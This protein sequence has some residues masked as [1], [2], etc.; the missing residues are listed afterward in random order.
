M[1]LILLGGS[2]SVMTYGLNSGL[3]ERN[4]VELLNYSLGATSSLQNLSAIVEHIEDVKKADLIV[5]ESNVNDLSKVN[6]LG[7]DVGVVADSIDLYYR[8]LYLLEC[9]VIVIIMPFHKKN[10]SRKLDYTTVEI[11]KVHIQSAKKYGFDYID[12]AAMF[13]DLGAVELEHLMCDR[14]HPKPLLMHAIGQSIVQYSL[15]SADTSHHCRKGLWD[16]HV[17]QDLKVVTADQL[18]KVE[19]VERSNNRF[20]SR[21]TKISDKVHIPSD[22]LGYRLLGIST[23]G[24]GGLR[25]RNQ[26]AEI[27]KYFSDLRSFQ[28]LVA[29]FFIT[30]DTFLEHSIQPP[31]EKS[32]NVEAEFRSSPQL[33]SLLLIN[34]DA[35]FLS[36]S[37][38]DDTSRIENLDKRHIVPELSLFIYDSAR[39]SKKYAGAYAQ[40]G[41]LLLKSGE[42]ERAESN[43]KIALSINPREAKFYLTMSRILAKKGDWSGAV[44]SAE[45]AASLAPQNERIKAHLENLLARES[46]K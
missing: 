22:C 42:I 44:Q 2:N 31:T 33:E 23:W 7:V 38:P 32:I 17:K 41:Q 40:L 8:T 18:T 11:N 9:R 45:S 16:A 1:R 20:K 36:I 4:E 28:D 43:Q 30:E 27:I 13:D 35:H 21:L 10:E 6:V 15:A 26:E 34:V 24:K 12:L 5:T 37:P 39:N 3:A 25:L 46:R 19:V 29:P 14:R